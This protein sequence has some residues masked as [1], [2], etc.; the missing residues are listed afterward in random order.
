M[1]NIILSITLALTSLT[2][3]AQS[4]KVLSGPMLGYA[5]MREA[6]VWVQLKEAGQVKLRFWESNQANPEFK[7]TKT[8]GTSAS[9]ANTA[10]LYL[11]NLEPGKTYTY[12]VWVD[13]EKQ[14]FDY[15]LLLSTEPLWDYRTEPPAFKI[16]LGS[17]NYINEEAYDRPGT[18]YGGSYEIFKSITSKNPEAM[19]WMG[20]N[21]YLR[22][23]DWWTRS[24]YLA[25]YTHTRSLPEIQEL[26]A[27]CPNYAI[28]DDHD[29]GPNDASGSWI[30]K[31]LALEV[32]QLFW[33]N[34]SF[35]YRE[36]PSTF[37][38]FNFRDCDFIMLD[39]R[40]YRTETTKQ[41]DIYE[42]QMFGKK[43]IDLMIDLLKQSKAPF[44]FVLSG[45]QILNN[46]KVYEN[47][48]NYEDE[49]NY[50]L[51]RIADE[52]IENVI[53]L[54]GDRHHSEVMEMELENGIVIYEF[55]VSPL[56]SSANKNVKEVNDY[57]VAGSL[58][59]ERN[60]ATIEVEGPRKSRSL[61]LQF[62]SSAGELIYEYKLNP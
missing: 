42:E 33:A 17:C 19:L 5:E 31:D 38:A 50:M 10:K 40:F 54:S 41:G 56:T 2:T 57:R 43:Q 11:Q 35:G 23:A 39:N 3:A 13:E 6:V 16:A 36:M 25:R 62:F 32:F 15:P 49:R 44:K 1:K 47:F 4:S 22:P 14:D 60:F 7:W 37:S 27:A 46:A 48:S 45:G 51:D 28:W 29:F 34:P 52:E 12:E 9:T 61:K 58:I 55:T 8:V 20:D 30:H 21:T 59:Q 18:P 53:F 26:L 24:G